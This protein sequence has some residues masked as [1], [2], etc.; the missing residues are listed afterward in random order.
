MW[1]QPGGQ[2]GQHYAV[3][4]SGAGSKTQRGQFGSAQS[5]WFYPW[6]G[7]RRAARGPCCFRAAAACCLC[8]LL[9]AGG[10]DSCSPGS[11][12]ASFSTPPPRLALS[13]ALRPSASRRGSSPPS[14]TRW[15]AASRRGR[16]G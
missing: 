2:R 14:F 6:S 5:A 4:V 11:P 13:Q 12:P 10:L 9:G 1:R 8:V 3:L 7:G 15:K 16:K